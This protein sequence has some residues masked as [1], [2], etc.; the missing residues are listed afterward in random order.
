MKNLMTDDKARLKKWAEAVKIFCN[1]FWGPTIENCRELQMGSLQLM[2]S[3]SLEKEE[4][5]SLTDQLKQI[6]MSYPSPDALQEELESVYIR[7][8][9][10][11][12]GGIQTPLYHSSYGEGNQISNE[13]LMGNPL[14]E[15]NERF[16]EIG[17]SVMDGI[18]EPADHISLELEYLFYLLQQGAET[19]DSGYIE[20]AVDFSRNFMLPWIKQL[21]G[22]LNSPPDK[23][24]YPIIVEMLVL[25]LEEVAGD[26]LIP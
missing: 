5:Q 9:I 24:F 14:Q 3:V 19:G 15:M 7:Q 20:G 18:H 6:V 23:I 25:L 26:D 12:Q 21:S 16:A 13:L 8:F 4:V 10:N 17:L 22:R 1:L 11:D 2:M